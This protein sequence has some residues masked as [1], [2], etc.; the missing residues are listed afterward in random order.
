MSDTPTPAPVTVE[1]IVVSR[2][3][4]PA[5]SA[6][7]AA[8]YPRAV[9]VNEVF[10]SVQGEGKRAGDPSVFVRFTGCNMQ[11][12]NAPGPRSPGGFKC[13]TE[14]ESG[15]RMKLAALLTEVERV[16]VAASA[17]LPTATRPVWIVFTGGEP[18]LQLTEHLC[19]AF[20]H[21]GY[22]LAVETN[23]SVP[24]P[25]HATPPPYAIANDT[26]LGLHLACSSLDWIT[27][28][29]KVAEHA[30]EQ[31]VAHEVKYVRGHGQAIPKTRVV[32]RHYLI[33]P[34]FN[35]LTIDRA[36]ADWC[37]KLVLANAPWGLSVQLHKGM[38]GLPV[39]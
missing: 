29:P 6:E 15:T 19:A 22:R 21:A 12:D 28:S 2:E 17:A 34:A 30:I 16:L 3:F 18:G 25:I 35:G 14:F 5:R 8:S 32:A 13:D 31:L 20:R 7:L 10:Y 26:D 39:R 24:L 23:G 9:T 36:A 27:V 11:C 4:N 1:S 38:L 37:T 33:S